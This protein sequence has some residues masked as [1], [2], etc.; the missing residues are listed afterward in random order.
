VAR[1]RIQRYVDAHLGGAKQKSNQGSMLRAV[2]RPRGALRERLHSQ[3]SRCAYGVSP[4]HVAGG[5]PHRSESWRACIPPSTTRNCPRWLPSFDAKTCR[6]ASKML[7]LCLDAHLVPSLV[8]DAI[9]KS[10]ASTR[11]QLF[12]ARFVTSKHPSRR[13]KIKLPVIGGC[14]RL[15]SERLPPRPTVVGCA[16]VRDE[17]EKR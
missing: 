15:R 11:T 3:V 1:D 13:S 10:M 6:D 4:F 17:T 2:G 14:R 9:E 16:V 7:K 8:Q 12:I 5:D